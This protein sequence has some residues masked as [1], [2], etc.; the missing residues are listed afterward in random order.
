MDIVVNHAFVIWH[1]FSQPVVPVVLPGVN[2]GALNID[3]GSDEGGNRGRE[4]ERGETLSDGFDLATGALLLDRIG[5][6]SHP[7]V[8][9]CGSSAM[10]QVD[11]QKR[12]DLVPLSRAAAN[13][14]RL[15]AT[16]TSI[17]TTQPAVP[18][19]GATN[20]FGAG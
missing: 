5:L 17:D 4:K 15:V 20:F 14:V 19:A 16:A 6:E 1:A 3:T 11:V 18:V 7:Q 12:W 10:S 9:S 8:V 13:H 2:L